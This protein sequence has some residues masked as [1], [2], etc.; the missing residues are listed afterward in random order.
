MHK[1]QERALNILL[2]EDS[3]SDVRLIQEAFKECSREVST[4]FC[5]DGVD[6]L[7]FLYKQ[8]EYESA[9][10]P[11][12]I[13]LDLNMPKK[14]ARDIL[15]EIKQDKEL[16]SIPVIVFTTS[17]SEVDVR[18]CYELGANCFLIKPVDFDKFVE[19]ILS[20]E[21]FWFNMAILPTFND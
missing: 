2:V 19:V 4:H 17:N 14:D 16:K 13:I 21:S 20:I 18:K 6:A 3:K 11:D 8:G 7:R 5:K 15:V 9:L 12:L 10:K 1:I